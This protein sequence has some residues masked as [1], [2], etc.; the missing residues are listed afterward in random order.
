MNTPGFS[1]PP[2][3]PPPPLRATQAESNFNY[4]SSGR[5][6]GNSRDGHR[7]R[8]R[9]RGG[10]YRG[11]RGND[12]GGAGSGYG[13]HRNSGPRLPNA[14][15]QPQNGTTTQPHVY[16]RGPQSSKPF[17][18]QEGCGNH[19]TGVAQSTSAAPTY[20]SGFGGQ[21]SWMGSSQDAVSSAARH[22]AKAANAFL[23]P[24]AQAQRNS[25]AP[26]GKAPPAVPNFGF[27]LPVAQ[28][29]VQSK[30]IPSPKKKRKH[31]QLG[32]TPQMEAHESSEDDV[33]EESRL[34]ATVNAGG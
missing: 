3:P 12:Y 11:Q 34:G 26:N 17:Y 2:P 21:P 13:R 9:G 18:G 1:F 16:L 22:A 29:P 7:G 14:F 32:L 19:G 6:F 8:G 27:S 33:D 4:P 31:N 30:A 15:S 10:S 23:G 5:G 24:D 28:G 20:H 25:G